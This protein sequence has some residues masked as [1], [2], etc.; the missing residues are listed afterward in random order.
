MHS[1]N[2]NWHIWARHAY[3]MTCTSSSTSSLV[4][5]SLGRHKQL[6]LKMSYYFG[7]RLKVWLEND[8]AKC[9][10]SM[11]STKIFRFE[12]H[13]EAT[14]PEVSLPLEQL[15]QHVLELRYIPAHTLARQL[16]IKY[17]ITECSKL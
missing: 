8:E 6:L 3:K 10:K 11:L 5:E 7:R 16:V 14:G 2:N 9:S 13:H 15:Y 4:L 12:M 17:I 1:T